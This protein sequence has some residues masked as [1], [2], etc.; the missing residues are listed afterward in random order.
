MHFDYE[1]F[2]IEYECPRCGAICDCIEQRFETVIL[3][4]YT[5]RHIMPSYANVSDIW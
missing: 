5:S 2:K 4:L 3:S 1:Y